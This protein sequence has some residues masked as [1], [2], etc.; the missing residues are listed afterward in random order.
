MFI[1]TKIKIQVLKL[2][3]DNG[4]FLLN[5]K[6]KL[7]RQRIYSPKFE[8]D[9]MK[10]FLYFKSI[11]DLVK[12][13]NGNIVE[14]GVASGRSLLM[15][16]YLSYLY[17][18]DYDSKIWGFDSFE[19][20]PKPS[21][22][23]ISPRNPKKGE[24]SDTSTSYIE[25]LLSDCDIDNKFIDNN[26]NLIKGFLPSSASNYDKS[27]IA[28]LHIDVDLYESTKAS[29]EE[30]YQYVEPGGVV[31]FDEYIDDSDNWPGAVKAI[32]DFFGTQTSLFQRDIY[33][34]KYFFQ[35]PKI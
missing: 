8:S 20:F 15:L 2:L 28:I 25:R 22:E 33:S 16:S 26:V 6:H 5:T 32:Q 13:V 14:C 11:I 3:R 10:Y 21:K 34:R 31:M 18:K 12:N 17:R 29:L 7:S 24:H 35:K 19:G 4:Y 27:P 23:D 1:T 9:N 30:F